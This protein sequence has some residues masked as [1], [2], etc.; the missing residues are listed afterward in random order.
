MSSL[1]LLAYFSWI[2]ADQSDVSEDEEDEADEQEE[3]EEEHFVIQRN[4]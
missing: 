2:G 3:E 4:Y 1:K